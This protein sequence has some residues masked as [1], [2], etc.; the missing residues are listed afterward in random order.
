MESILEKGRISGRQL[1]FCVASFIHGSTLLSSFVVGITKQ[2][3]W[4][5]I[6]AAFAVCVLLALMYITISK[7]FPGKNIISIND[8]VFGKVFG[9]VVSILY[10]WFFLSLTFLNTREVGNF[11]IGF[12]M[13][14]T[15]LVAI[16]VLIILTC[17]YAINKGIM[18]LARISF[19]CM[20]LMISV[21][22]LNTL[23]LWPD[24][25]FSNFAP[26]FTLPLIDYVHGTHTLAILPFSEIMV[27]LMIF[28]YVDEKYD[29]KKP[30]LKG[31]FIGFVVMLLTAVRDWAALGSIATMVS[32]LTFQAVRIINV[33]E[34]F[35][36]MEVLFAII[37]FV[38]QFFK[39]SI[40]FYATTLG[41]AQI[42]GLKSYKPLVPVIG[43]IVVCL[44]I[45]VWNSVAEASYWGMYVAAVY[46]TFF[47]VVIPGITLIIVIAKGFGKKLK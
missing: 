7:K 28:P 35:T 41:V 37:L 46:S 16:S 4:V 29:I 2:D 27:F 24:M 26:S 22:V 18:T 36:R 23:L 42:F 11:V 8:I 25:N 44:S 39:I 30:F 31:I 5:A 38:L 21:I 43:A 12:V 40:L 1:M 20:I 14:L 10:L 45:V 17:A 3:T 32:E 19:L 47:E 33:G 6:I 13:P 34:I 15:P 9:K